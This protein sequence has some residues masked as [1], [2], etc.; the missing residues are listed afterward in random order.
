MN[1]MTRLL[2]VLALL[3]AGGCS[4]MPGFEPI[5]P[6]DVWEF[7]SDDPYKKPTRFTVIE[8]RRGYVLYDMD[9]ESGGKWRDHNSEGWFRLGAHRIGP[10]NAVE[11]GK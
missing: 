7:V 4:K 5:R 2:L 6:G 10:T 11:G 1:G 9:L 3:A 8:V